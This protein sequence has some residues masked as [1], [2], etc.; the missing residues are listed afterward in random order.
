QT[1]VGLPDATGIV[2]HIDDEPLQLWRGR[3]IAHE[4]RLDFRSGALE[5]QIEWEAP[6][7][8]R[9]SIR[10]W[11]IVSFQHR[12]LAAFRLEVTVLAGRGR[13]SLVSGILN[14]PREAARHELDPRRA[15]FLAEALEPLQSEAL[16]NRLLVGC[17]TRNS[18]MTA[19]CVVQQQLTTAGA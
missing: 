4:R 6:S 18:G 19:V 14:R 8:V 10:S 3:L 5:R 2:L 13:L 9:L 15:A 7:G 12:H 1:I 17:R 16:A 11:R